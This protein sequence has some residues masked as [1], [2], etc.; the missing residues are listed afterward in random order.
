M[1]TARRRDHHEPERPEVALTPRPRRLL[2]I[3]RVVA[4]QEAAVREAQ[5]RFPREAAAAAGIA[6]VEAFIGSGYYAVALEIDAD[7]I[8]ETLAAYFNDPAIQALHAEL[9]P[10]VEGLPG[11]GWRY[12][13]ADAFH[14]DGAGSAGDDQGSGPL[15]GSADLPLAASMYRWRIGETPQTG[16]V[17]HGPSRS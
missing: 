12:G 10:V 4:G 9:Q 11:P 3:G 14:E 1:S 7:D 2:L 17:P 16:A 6:A 13:P 5:A 15:L 8:Q